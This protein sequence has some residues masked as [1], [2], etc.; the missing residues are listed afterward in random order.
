MDWACYFEKSTINMEDLII[1]KK[2]CLFLLYATMVASLLAGCSSHDTFT[3]GSYTADAA[4][5]Q[6]VHIDVR[7]RQIEVCPSSD[8]RIHLAYSESSKESYLS[9]IHI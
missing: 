4:Q 7:D 3:Q 5:I 9:L 6:S 1:M 2:V 8:D